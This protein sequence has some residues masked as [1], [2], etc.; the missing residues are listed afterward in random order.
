MGAEI[1][2]CSARTLVWSDVDCLSFN[3][4]AGRRINSRST[5]PPIQLAKGCPALI[6]FYR[7]SSLVEQG[8]F[9]FEAT[10]AKSRKARGYILPRCSD[11]TL[12][13]P[14]L[15]LPADCFS[16]IGCQGQT[17]LFTPVQWTCSRPAIW[18]RAAWA[19]PQWEFRKCQDLNAHGDLDILCFL[20]R[21]WAR[22]K[23]KG[24]RGERR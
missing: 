4:Q 7:D 2:L 12:D 19:D 22:S 23:R 21:L 6:V 15:W 10:G 13:F 5:K 3:F 9:G 16:V 8:N 17:G 11:G 18:S 24:E 14:V 20:F 1:Y